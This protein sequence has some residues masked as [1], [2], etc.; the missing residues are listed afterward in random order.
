M[1]AR[2]LR[3]TSVCPTSLSAAGGTLNVSE[4]TPTSSIRKPSSSL[5]R[6]TLIAVIGRGMAVLGGTSNSAA[7]RQ[8]LRLVTQRQNQTDEILH[9]FAAQAEV[10]GTLLAALDA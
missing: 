4:T 10:H 9:V 8:T 7:G 2:A 1:E 3:A 6:P 5:V